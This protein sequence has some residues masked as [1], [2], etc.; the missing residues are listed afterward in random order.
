MPVKAYIPNLLTLG[1]LACGAVAIV[2]LLQ[3]LGYMPPYA[4][5]GWL[6]AAGMVFDFLDGFAARTLGVASPLGKELDSLSDMVTFGLLPGMLVFHVLFYH[7]VLIMEPAAAATGANAVLPLPDESGS[8]W[9]NFARPEMPAVP[10]H[11]LLPALAGLLIPVFSAIRLAK[12][13]IDT[14]QSYGFR[15]LAT[16]ANAFFFLSIFL[17]FGLDREVQN[18]F[19]PSTWSPLGQDNYVP[20]P[21]M[22]HFTGGWLDTLHHPWVLLV[23]TL[24]FSVLLITNIPLLAFKFR[25]AALRPNLFRYLLILISAVII[26]IFSYRGIPLVMVAYFACS[27][28]EYLRIRSGGAV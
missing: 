27:L 4:T 1:N 9:A 23:L 22:V 11:R 25:S 18:D 15:G 13:N 10:W 3:P 16:P 5:I 20:L 24:L 8:L 12:F 6:M 14:R 2:L 17:I 21:E 26:A 28:G 7:P 19:L